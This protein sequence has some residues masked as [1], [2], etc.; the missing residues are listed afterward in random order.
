MNTRLLGPHVPDD[1]TRDREPGLTVADSMTGTGALAA[2]LAVAAIGTPR[3][4]TGH[5][6]PAP[7][8]RQ[9]SSRG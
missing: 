1:A 7:K 2:V 4:R 5:I 8:S 6:L 3:L 9:K